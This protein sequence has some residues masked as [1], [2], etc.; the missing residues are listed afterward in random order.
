M[1]QWMRSDE[2][3][4]YKSTIATL[5]QDR[6]LRP[7]FI[8]KKSVTEQI[9]WIHKTLQLKTCN[10]IGEH[11]LQVFF[12]KGQEKI[13]VTFCDSMGIEHDGK[14]SVDGDLPETLDANKLKSAVDTLLAEYS[15]QLT[16]LYLQVFNM[17]TEGGWSTLSDLLASDDRLK[18]N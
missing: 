9:A 16:T 6:R 8:Q 1:F 12:M 11:L 17:Q 18:L 4:L 14:G 7:V 15:P 10:M 5:A 13:L 2:R 3:D